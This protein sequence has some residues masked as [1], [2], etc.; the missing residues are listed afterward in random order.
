MI[1]LI[2]MIEKEDVTCVAESIG[3]KLTDEQV[4]QIIEE[5]PSWAEQDPTATWD[6]IVEDLVHFVTIDD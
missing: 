6:L 3:K 5:Y 1:K 4:D 2:D